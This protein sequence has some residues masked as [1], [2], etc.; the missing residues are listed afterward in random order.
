MCTCSV[1]NNKLCDTERTNYKM[2]K[3]M[4]EFFHHRFST[5][6]RIEAEYSLGDIPVDFLNCLEK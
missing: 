1:K 2:R 4:M 5:I 3:A 6:A